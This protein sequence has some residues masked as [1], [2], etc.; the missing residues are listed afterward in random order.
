MDKFLKALFKT[1]EVL[2]AVFLAIMIVM[3]FMNVVLRQFGKGF[4]W[5]EEIARIAFIYLVYMGTI[6]AAR[7]NRHLLIDSVLTRIPEIAQKIMYC[8]VQF[9]IIWMM[10]MLTVGSW[11][12]TMQNIH[13]KW[14][15]THYPTFM[16]WGVG[17]LTGGSIVILSLVNIVR[18]I[19]FKASVADLIKVPDDGETSSVTK[20]IG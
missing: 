19:F 9:I 2:M 10:G 5:S 12:I 17:L 13:D 18:L 7:D 6:G 1:V 4:V 8:L 16:V 14:V 15:A 3:L 20:E 11:G